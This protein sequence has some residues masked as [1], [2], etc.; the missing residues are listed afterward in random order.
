M[1]A[2]QVFPQRNAFATA[3][4]VPARSFNR[5]FGHAMA[6]HFL[7]QIADSARIRNVVTNDHRRQKILQSGPGSFGPFV[8]IKRTFT[9]GA[10]APAF[11]AFGI[12]D[13][14]QDNA[15]FS[16]TAKTGF[17]KVNQRQAYLAQLD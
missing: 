11:R 13:P 12:D 10:L 7:H 17:K 8:G 2:P 9:G 15:A 4:Q 6:A 14:G 1:N 5:G 3:F 16:G